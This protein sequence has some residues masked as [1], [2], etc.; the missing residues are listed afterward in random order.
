MYCDC[1]IDR[2]TSSLDVAK[3]LSQTAVL[4]LNGGL[5]T[6]MGLAKAKSLL[7]VKDDMTF[8]DIIAKQILLLTDNCADL[9]FAL[10][11]DALIFSTWS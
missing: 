7:E 8:L 5:G 6:S 11:P 1:K 2:G 9:R 10:S 4:K 3:L